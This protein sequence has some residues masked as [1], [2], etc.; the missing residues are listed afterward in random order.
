M[1][2][3]YYKQ[4]DNYGDWHLIFCCNGDEFTA[5]TNDEEVPHE[6]AVRQILQFIEGELNV[7]EKP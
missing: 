2:D 3:I 5:A 1:D 7:R 4:E 6:E